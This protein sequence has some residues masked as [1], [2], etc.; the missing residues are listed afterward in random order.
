MKLQSPCSDSLSAGSSNEVPANPNLLYFATVKISALPAE[1]SG[2]KPLSESES[3]YFT[4]HNSEL[5]QRLG[6]FDNQYSPPCLRPVHSL[7]Q[8][9]RDQYNTLL[10]QAAA[11]E[12]KLL[13]MQTSSTSPLVDTQT[14]GIVEVVNTAEILLLQVT[15]YYLSALEI[16][17]EDVSLHGKLAYLQQCMLHSDNIALLHEF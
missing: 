14:K 2:K 6:L 11:V 1:E 8:E 7:F 15:Q 5:L 4:K 12:A 13:L 10:L 3:L 9:E 17:D 16:C